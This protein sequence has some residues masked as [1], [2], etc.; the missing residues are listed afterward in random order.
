[1]HFQYATCPGPDELISSRSDC[2]VIDIVLG[3]SGT[4]REYF[5][6]EM[7]AQAQSWPDKNLA[8]TDLRFPTHSTD[9]IRNTTSRSKT[10]IADVGEKTT[11]L[12]WDWA[13]HVCR[14]HPDRWASIAT[15]WMP[16]K[17]PGRG[18]PRRRWRDDLDAFISG[19]PEKALQREL[20]KSGGE[21][22]AQQWDTTTG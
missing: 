9:R 16:Q 12:K 5:D 1:M 14:M 2:E 15:K 17:K 10:R 3:K 4:W 22:F 18:W 19:W 11:R 7:R 21:A 8:D 20:C 13:G 6:E